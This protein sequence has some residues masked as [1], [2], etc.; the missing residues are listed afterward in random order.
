MSKA[1]RAKR[2]S[3]AAPPPPIAKRS[4]SLARILGAITLGVIVAALV[5]FFALRGD[6]T[7]NAQSQLRTDPAPW[8]PTASGLTKRLTASHVPFSNMEGTALHIHPQL[9]IFIDGGQVAVPANIG[10]EPSGQTMAALHTHDDAGTIHVESPVVRKYTLG[11]FFDVWGVRLT[12]NCIG[13]Y[14]TGR[15]KLL[16]AFADGKRYRG[17]P[18]SL[19]LRDKEQILVAYGTKADIARLTS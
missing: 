19:A 9:A 12:D 17:D 10:I 5:G 6:T 14:C 4:R 15:G 18:R 13:G 16:A 8:P 11:E 2:E 3:K 7:R 1:N